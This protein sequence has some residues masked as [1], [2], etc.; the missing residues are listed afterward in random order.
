MDYEFWRLNRS[1]VKKERVERFSDN[2]TC[3]EV[4]GG[5]DFR[6]EF[7]GEERQFA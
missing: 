7:N 3:F 2:L 1:K 4:V 5:E 6:S